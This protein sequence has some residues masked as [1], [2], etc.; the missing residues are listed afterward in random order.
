MPEQPIPEIALPMMKQLDAGATPD[1]SDPNSKMPMAPR[2]VNLMGQKV[3][4]F[5]QNSWKEQL[6]RK[7]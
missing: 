7:L 1:N 3:Y 4:S 5:P 6:V 2:K